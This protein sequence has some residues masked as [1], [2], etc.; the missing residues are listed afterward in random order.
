MG[1]VNELDVTPNVPHTKITEDLASL[2][3]LET[4]L[5]AAL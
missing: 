4:Q 3:G 5:F 2:W 1:L